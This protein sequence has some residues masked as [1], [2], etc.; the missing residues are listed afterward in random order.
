MQTKNLKNYTLI[1]EKKLDDI[2]SEGY[3]LEHN[4]TK[5]KVVLIEN[6]DSNKTFLVGFRTPVENSTGVPHIM[7]HSV[8]CGSRKFPAKDPF[9]ELVKGSLNTFLNA[10]TFP[11]K[12]IFPV[13]SENDKDFQNLMDIYLDAVFYPKIYE[14]RETFCQEGWTYELKDSDDELKVNGVVYNEMKG[15]F[16]APD[17]IVERKIMNTLYP[18]TGYAFESG[19][20][21][22]EIP[23]LSYEEF[24]AFHKKYYH[25]S[26][27]YI[28]LYGNMD[29]LE[30]LD[31]IDREYLSKFDYQDIDSEIGRQDA[32]EEKREFTI[33]YPVAA[34]EPV[35]E[36]TYLS[37]NTVAGEITD[38]ELYVAFQVLEYALVEMPGAPVKQAL[39]D[40]GI[41]KDVEGKYNNWIYQ[42]Y[43]S[44]IAKNAEQTQKDEF[45]STIF[46]TLNA[47]VRDG[48]DRQSLNAALNYYEFQY[49][50]ADFG[51]YP[52]GVMLSFQV[53]DSWLYKNDEPFMHLQEN[54][55][56]ETL[57]KKV[58]TGYFEKL[59]EEYFINNNHA[60]VVVAVP[61]RGMTSEHDENFKKELQA[62][63][64]AMSKEELE[65][66]MSWTK[67]IEEYK[68]EESSKE[69]LEKI[70]MLSRS[71]ISPDVKTFHNEEVEY[72]GMQIIYHDVFT[73]GIGY[74][75]AIFDITDI[76][77][78]YYYYVG[79]LKAVMGY[80][81]TE[82]Y[83]YTQLT[84][85]INMNTGGISCDTSIVTDSIDL[86]KYSIKVSFG[87]KVFENK[88]GFA[89]K[90]I[91]EMINT[92]KVSDE[93]RLLEILSELKA[94]LQVV[95]SH[96]GD[97]IALIRNMSYYSES[98]YL[99]E[100][101]KGIDF[102]KFVDD[103]VKN[104]DTRK[105]E[106]IEGLEKT[107]RYVFRKDNVLYSYTSEKTGLE[108][109]KESIKEFNDSL[110]DKCD[111][112]EKTGID[113]KRKNEGFKTS[114]QIQYVTRS[115]SFT[116]AGFSYTGSLRVLRTILNFEYLWNNVR[117][118]GGAYGCS[119]GFTRNGD[120]FFSSYR[121]PKL[122]ETNQVFERIPK[123]I[124]NFEADEREMTKYVIGTISSMDVPLT[125]RTDGSRSMTAY[126]SRITEDD[127]RKE[128]KE[129]L[130][131]QID[132]IRKHADMIEAVLKQGNICV[133]GNEENIEKEKEL[134]DITVDLF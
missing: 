49:R 99:S 125:P 78:K 119:S 130:E 72:E 116:K 77:E 36:N 1:Q 134:F 25:P 40:K 58:D 87:A 3:L 80:M 9:I 102:Y 128:R 51:S 43:F 11:D 100:Q 28:Y 19:G 82:N 120:C 111:I 126:L 24:L 14:R 45:V 64:N 94:E 16:S 132:D 59:V 10:M 103:C 95:F 66:L 84:N 117:V 75:N 81:N 15:A 20:D 71:D 13:A 68:S 57:R 7:E 101:L 91:Q 48:I 88:I 92:T 90:M 105:S 121:D 53:F 23:D 122:R 73:N 114:A 31:Y 118:L 37:Y 46:D 30:K 112:G 4:K 97:S 6:D 83:T 34:N 65:T 124:R 50:E 35:E 131:A 86:E 63:K 123:F 89:L 26:N 60:S 39:L 129:V 93:K 5:A 108:L 2:K 98:A 38:K 104:F 67:H 42:P 29:M 113:I 27:S 47:L 41:G 12:T 115:G 110:Y 21:P 52:K 96:S 8:L 61:K 69:D 109:L 18:D 22:D 17:Q 74:L 55:V 85:E 56:F 107:I 32:F 70:P 133:V 44:I 127:L 54:E 33:E 106:I 79:L 76:P 62:K